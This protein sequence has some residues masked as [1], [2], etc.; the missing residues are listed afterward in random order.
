MRLS[1]GGEG[2]GARPALL[3]HGIQRYDQQ[4]HQQP[5]RQ[6]HARAH[7]GL[8]RGAGVGHGYSCATAARQRQHQGVEAVEQQAAGLGRGHGYDHRAHDGE[9]DQNPESARGGVSEQPAA[10]TR[11][12]LGW[13][14]GMRLAQPLSAPRQGLTVVAVVS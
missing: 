10:G 13:E 3:L 8:A 6:R 5:Q 7:A 14:G 9:R 11:G 12:E 2:R 4:Q 1:T